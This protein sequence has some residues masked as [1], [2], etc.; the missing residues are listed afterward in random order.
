MS[1]VRTNSLGL[2]VGD[3]V[4]VRSEEEILATLD[5]QG[6]LDNLPFMPEML[7]FC[8]QRV[9]VEKRADKTCNTI[10]VMESRRLR[11]TVHLEGLRCN[12][13]AHGGC[14][15]DCLIFW[16]EAWLKRIPVLSSQ[17]PAPSTGLR[18]DRG[19]LT[20]LTLRSDPPKTDEPYYRCQITDLLKASTPMQWW[21]MRQYWR[22]YWSGN[23]GLI[24]MFKAFLFRVFL[25]LLHIGVGYRALLWTYERFQKLTGGTP[26]PLRNGNLDK[27]PKE[28][29]D[30]RP[31][32]L[33][34]IKPYEEILATLSKKNKNRGLWFGPEMVPYCGELRRVRARVEHIIE[35]STG[36]MMQ[37]PGDCVVLEGVICRAEYSENRL[38][39]P[40]N[41]FPYWREIWLRRAERQP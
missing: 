35:E 13:Q 38:F 22:D 27:T 6:A 33:V 16:K 14:Q 4:E 25:E 17:D 7:S 8:G 9:R 29:L 20:Q 15:A 39:C 40:R 36:R 11:D 34:Q 41:L 23:V 28:T 10:T 1:R 24:T 19:R 3:F 30:L 12:G 5:D 2:R 31:G 18:C 32:E 26:Y 21:D 37:L